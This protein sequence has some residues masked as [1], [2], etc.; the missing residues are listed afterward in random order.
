MWNVTISTTSANWY[1]NI[2][3]LKFFFEIS[4]GLRLPATKTKGT[5]VLADVSNQLVGCCRCGISS[6]LKILAALQ[7]E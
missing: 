4:R 6:G 5:F 7:G 1:V 3:H 2:F